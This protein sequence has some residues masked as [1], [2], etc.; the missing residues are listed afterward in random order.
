LRG[1]GGI[2]RGGILELDSD[3]WIFGILDYW[4]CFFWILLAYSLV[5]PFLSEI[6][7]SPPDDPELS[8]AENSTSLKKGETKL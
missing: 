8:A 5:S 6:E 1:P 7:F 3:S 2:D 4:I